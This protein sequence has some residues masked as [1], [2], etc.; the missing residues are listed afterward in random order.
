M[1]IPSKSTSTLW[2]P[3]TVGM[4]SHFHVPLPISL[5]TIR[6]VFVSPLGSTMV[7]V[8]VPGPAPVQELTFK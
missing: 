8:G 2:L 1:G 4:Y 6:A 3:T 7:T 5:S